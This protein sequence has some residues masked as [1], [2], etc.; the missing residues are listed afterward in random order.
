[1]QLDKNERQVNSNQLLRVDLFNGYNFQDTPGYVEYH[2]CN[3]IVRLGFYE[4]TGLP[5][6]DENGVQMYTI[7]KIP[8]QSGT[9]D[10]TEDLVNQWGADDQIVF[11]YVIQ[12]LNL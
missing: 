6:L 8:I 9:I 7:S 11:D 12:Q 2:V 10:L 5:V 3:Y 4:D 1:M